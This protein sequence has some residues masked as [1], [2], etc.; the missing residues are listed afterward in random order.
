MQGEGNV[1]WRADDALIRLGM[2]MGIVGGGHLTIGGER[3]R[4]VPKSVSLDC[5]GDFEEGHVGLVPVR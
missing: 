5:A 4:D 3:A 1:R 2:A